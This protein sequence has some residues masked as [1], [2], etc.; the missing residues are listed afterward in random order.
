MLVKVI[1][2][3]QG[4][5]H[6]TMNFNTASVIG[7]QV[8]KPDVILTSYSHDNI[9]VYHSIRIIHSPLTRQ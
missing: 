3:L 2:L 4:E 8:Q 7:K 5:P 9:K 6:H 1:S